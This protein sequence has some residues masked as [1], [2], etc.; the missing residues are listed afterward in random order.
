MGRSVIAVFLIVAIACPTWA[1]GIPKNPQQRFVPTGETESYATV[2]AL[3]GQFDSYYA[4]REIPDL[5]PGDEAEG[6]EGDESSGLLAENVPTVE[7]LESPET[8][9]VVVGNALF[10]TDQFLGQFPENTVFLLNAIDWM[11]LGD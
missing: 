3:A 2:A 6:E 11:T 5:T 10:A 9:L 1:G 7:L 8:R 4:E